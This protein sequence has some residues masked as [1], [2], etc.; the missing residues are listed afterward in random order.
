M[1]AAPQS[2][3]QDLPLLKSQWRSNR[4]TY[5]LQTSPSNPE[6][7]LSP[8]A[9]SSPA[10]CGP[11]ASLRQIDEAARVARYLRFETFTELDRTIARGSG[12]DVAIAV[13]AQFL[14]GV[15]ASLSGDRAVA[16]S[17]ECTM[18][19]LETRTLELT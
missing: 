11:T 15:G 14:Q 8:L 6:A 12:H 16:R 3:S 10:H 7:A 13:W 18:D 5:S 17:S 2:G 9:T 1:S 4:L 19:A